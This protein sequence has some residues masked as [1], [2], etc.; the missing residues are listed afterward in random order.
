M[1]IIRPIL[2]TVILF[3]IISCS[4][5]PRFRAGNINRPQK[6]TDKN[7]TGLEKVQYGIS[8]YYGPKFHGKLTANGEIFDMY[9]ISAAHRY[10]PLGTIIQVRNLDNNKTLRIRINDRGPYVNNRVLDCSYAA[11]LKLDFVEQGTANIK[12][13]VIEMG[14]GKR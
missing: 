3:S 7:S 2:I 14:T 9:K 5:N 13:V 4:A 10:L 1:G 11:A 8:S 12:L 6:N